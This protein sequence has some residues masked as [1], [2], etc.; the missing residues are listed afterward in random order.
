MIDTNAQ[1]GDG[2]NANSAQPIAVVQAEPTVAASVA[3]GVVSSAVA[4]IKPALGEVDFLERAHA[5]SLWKDSWRRLK[6]NRL[7]FAS[8]IFICFMSLVAILAQHLAPY[9]YETENVNLILASPSWAHWLGTDDLGRDLLSR[10]IYGA[11]VS[12]A[13]GVFTAIASLVFGTVYGA[14]SGWFG[15]RVDAVMMRLVDTL[16]SIPALVLLVLIKVMFDAVSINMNP[17]L[18]AVSGILVALSVLGWT[19]LARVVRGQVLQAKQLLFVEAARS[20]GA[21]DRWIVARHIVPNIMGPII[22]MITALIPQNIMFESV[23][24]FIGL[25][26]QPPYSSWGVLANEGWKTIRTFPHLIIAPGLALF[27]TLLAFNIFGDGLRDAW[28]PK[29]K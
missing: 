9:S 24:S 11:Q 27:F 15:G 1:A 5:S 12:M 28:D 2:P 29:A 8:A 6:R 21:T 26:L 18:R 7:A 17:E 3:V 16:D 23:L 25:G 10:V 22:V 4:D 19:M 14:I 20:I 13:V